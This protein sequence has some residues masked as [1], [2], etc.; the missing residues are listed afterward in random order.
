MKRK[1]VWIF[2]LLVCL[3]SCGESKLKIIE[4]KVI[5]ETEPYTKADENVVVRNANIGLREETVEIYNWYDI[6]NEIKELADKD[7]A[8]FCIISNL[9]DY[10]VFPV[11]CLEISKKELKRK[12]SLPYAIDILPGYAKNE[13]TFKI[14]NRPKKI[15]L[16]FYQVTGRA[17]RSQYEEAVPGETRLVYSLVVELTDEIGWHRLNIRM[18]PIKGVYEPDIGG[19][20]IIEDV[21]PGE[22]NLTAIS[23]IR[24]LYRKGEK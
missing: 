15:T 24:F 7:R 21:Y 8:T 10:L 23:E 16:E 6:I 19:R 18:K 20:L 22:T 3:V 13:K 4:T 1:K 14:Y 9:S 2:C 5:S 11:Y 17:A 12:D